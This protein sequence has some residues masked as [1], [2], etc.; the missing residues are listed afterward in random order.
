MTLTFEAR[1]SA[2]PGTY[3]D[4]L[5]LTVNSMLNEMGA[6]YLSEMPAQI[7]DM[8]DGAS[9]AGELHVVP[10]RVVAM[11]GYAS[12]AE[13]VNTAVLDGADVRSAVTVLRVLDRPALS[14]SLAG[15]GEYAC[16]VSD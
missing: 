11:L 13:L 7:H 12:S 5:S 14:P 9:A 2:L 4:A 10:V 3:E 6:R 15:L 8:R 1:A 16:S